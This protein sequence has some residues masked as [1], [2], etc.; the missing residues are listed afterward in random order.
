MQAK[1]VRNNTET[2][3]LADFDD[4][5]VQSDTSLLADTFENFKNMFIGIYELDPAKSYSPPGL[6]WQ[7]K[8]G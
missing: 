2:K 6:A 8:K 7:V 5:H 3:H 4:L 1:V